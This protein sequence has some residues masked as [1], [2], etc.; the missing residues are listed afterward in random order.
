M[1]ALETISGELNNLLPDAT[2]GKEEVVIEKSF[3]ERIVEIFKA[4][5]KKKVI[6][7][8]L[9]LG[10]KTVRK[11]LGGQ[12]W[13][14]YRRAS[15]KEPLLGSSQEWIGHRNPEIEY[16]GRVLFRELKEKGYRGKYDT[17]RKYLAPLRPA[18]GNRQMTVRFETLPGQQAQTEIRT[19]VP[20]F[21]RTKNKTL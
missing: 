16:N 5:K 3:H 17:V 2:H 10:I 6:A 9:G 8:L 20:T 18:T 4:V 7:R 14:P 19:L 21:G 12:E 13:V 11:I 1:E 15:L